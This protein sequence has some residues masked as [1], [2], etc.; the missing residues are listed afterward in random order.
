MT[1]NF[2]DRLFDAVRRK[3]SPLCVGLDPFLARIPRPIRD[4]AVAQHEDPH[5]AASEA[6][7]RFCER[8]VDVVADHAACVKIQMAFFEA[9][10]HH[11]IRAAEEVIDRARDRGLL[12]I[13]DV[14]RGDIG[15]T[16]AAFADAYFAG[17]EVNGERRAPLPFDAVTVN[18]YMGTDAVA[19]LARE[20]ARSGHGLFVLVRTSNPSSREI[21]D[22]ACDEEPL[23]HHVARLV[24]HWGAEIPGACGFHAV[25]AVV[26]ATFPTELARCRELMPSTPFLVPGVG[27]QGG[28][29]ADVAAAFRKDGLGA[30]VNS[31]RGILYAFEK[32]APGTAWEDAVAREARTLARSLHEVSRRS[33]HG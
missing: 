7:A 19:P 10:G 11:G 29:A 4:R 18:P 1:A 17:P 23:F 20:C 12:V 28:S 33:H 26:G 31:S 16:V 9:F 21:Q 22:L 6:I 5:A 8:V 13:G 32:A 3:S 30:V 27:A 15:S 2:S 14:K 25:G 24:D